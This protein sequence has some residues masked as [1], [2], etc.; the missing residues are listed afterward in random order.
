MARIPGSV[1]IMIVR[2]AES[3]PKSIKMSPFSFRLLQI[4]AILLLVVVIAESVAF[5]HLWAY[6]EERNQLLT[7]N[8]ELKEYN[9][10]VVQL[11]QDLLTNR[12]MLR[13]MTELV[14]I[15]LADF[16]WPE[17][18]PADSATAAMMPDHEWQTPSPDGRPHRIPSGLPVMGW[19]SRTF[20]PND[21]NP[22]MRHFGMDIAVRQGSDVVATADGRVSFAGWDQTFGWQVI[23]DHDAGLQTVYGHND[24]LLVVAGQPVHYGE[25]IALSGNTGISSAPHLHYEIRLNGTPVNP[26]NYLILPE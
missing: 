18:Q 16:G 26:E 3:S 19:V 17:L 24:T 8:A 1:T 5:G 4:L 6:A 22:K 23:I 21:D 13:K 7:E 15:D 20:R 14:G 11:E 12:V 10:K 25:K 2:D 9:A